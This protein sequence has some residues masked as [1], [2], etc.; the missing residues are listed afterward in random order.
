MIDDFDMKYE[1]TRMEDDHTSEPGDH[2]LAPYR[3]EHFAATTFE[4]LFATEL[5]VEWY[6]YEEAVNSL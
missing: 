3:L 4:R 2:P 1:A 6:E 5:G